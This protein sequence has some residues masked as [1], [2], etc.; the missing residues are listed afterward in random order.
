MRVRVARDMEKRQP[1]GFTYR[2]AKSE[3]VEAAEADWPRMLEEPRG[4]SAP[5]T[6][7]RFGDFLFM[8]SDDP[9]FAFVFRGA[10]IPA[11]EIDDEALFERLKS[12]KF[13]VQLRRSPP[14]PSS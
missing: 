14:L 3:R 12:G 5:G 7:P 11:V 9:D 10:D 2:F 1:M 6:D 4:F 13:E 8:T